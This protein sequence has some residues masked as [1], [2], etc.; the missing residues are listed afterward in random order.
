MK[1]QRKLTVVAIGMFS[2]TLFAPEASAQ[3][4]ETAQAGH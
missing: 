2:A 3:V 1:T 4:A